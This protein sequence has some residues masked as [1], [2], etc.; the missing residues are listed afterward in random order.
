MS[1]STTAIQMLLSKST[2]SAI[3]IEYGDAAVSGGISITSNFSVFGS[4][5]PILEFG[6]SVNQI[7]PS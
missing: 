4:K 3:G 1:L 7:L 5:F 2:L 6:V